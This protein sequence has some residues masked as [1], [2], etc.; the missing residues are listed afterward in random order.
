[1]D[2]CQDQNEIPQDDQVENPQFKCS[3][4]IVG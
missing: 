2:L 4:V 1:M 3:K